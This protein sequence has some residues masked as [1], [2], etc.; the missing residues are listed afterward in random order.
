MA[1]YLFWPTI[2]E[3]IISPLTQILWWQEA[4]QSFVVGKSPP[5]SP[6]TCFMY[7]Y[8]FVKCPVMLP[9]RVSLMHLLF[10]ISLWEQNRTCFCSVKVGKRHT[11]GL[12]CMKFNHGKSNKVYQCLGKP[13][14]SFGRSSLV[15]S[16]ERS[17][18]D[19]NLEIKWILKGIMFVF[20]S[21]VY[22]FISN[23][24]RHT[25]HTVEKYWTEISYDLQPAYLIKVSCV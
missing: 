2:C 14:Y 6:L 16:W 19:V 1:I 23:R 20:F 3:N 12:R 21:I 10:S 15:W 9:R 25:L 4:H 7:G 11:A 22:L 17:P 8:C 24:T 5:W 18:V 13:K